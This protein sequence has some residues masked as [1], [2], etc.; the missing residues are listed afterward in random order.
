MFSENGC[1][2]KRHR[3]WRAN[4]SQNDIKIELWALGGS[5]FVIWGGFWRGLI[6]DEFL[7]EKKLTKY[8]QK[9][10]TLGPEGHPIAILGAGRREGFGSWKVSRALQES[11]MNSGTGSCTLTPLQAGGG[12]F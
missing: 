3:K 11:C 5:I 7:I 1:F 8:L 2:A 12:G 9:C 4:G 10:G 6:L